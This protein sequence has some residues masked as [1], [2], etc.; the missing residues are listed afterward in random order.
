MRHDVSA[1]DPRGSKVRRPP[2]SRGDRTRR[3]RL[4]APEVGGPRS[5]SARAPQPR[6]RGLGPGLEAFS[7]AAAHWTGTSTAFALACLFLIVWAVSGPLFGFSNTWQLV[8]NTATTIVT[9]LMVF[10]IQRAQNKDTR[11]IEL[12]LNELL[13]AIRGASNRL[14]DVEHLSEAE[15][16]HLHRNFRKLLAEAERESSPT[17]PHSVEETRKVRG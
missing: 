10:L 2:P 14:I 4:H 11:A 1:R 13:A 3:L 15:L 6:R 16:E 5:A 8:I 17:N 9:F 12:K 7:R